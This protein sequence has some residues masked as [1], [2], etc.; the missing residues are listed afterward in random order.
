MNS[1]DLTWGGR[2]AMIAE[3]ILSELEAKKISAWMGITI[4]EEV[5]VNLFIKMRF[6]EEMTDAYIDAVMNAVK[7]KTKLDKLRFREE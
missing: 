4:M 1:E 7:I 5:L 3:L 6:S 2:A